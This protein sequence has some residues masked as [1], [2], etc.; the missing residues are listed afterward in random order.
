MTRVAPAENPWEE[1]ATTF[2]ALFEAYGDLH[3][4]MSYASFARKLRAGVAFCED[5]NLDRALAACATAGEDPPVVGGEGGLIRTEPVQRLLD[6]LC[7]LTIE[8]SLTGLFNRRYFRLRLEQEMHRARR[9]YQPLSVLRID[10]D[11]FKK[12]NDTFGH[13]A[14]DRTLCSIARS[15]SE[16]LRSSDEIP[17]RVGGEEFAVLLPDT[18]VAGARIAAERVRSTVEERSR[19]AGPH[20][21][22]SVGATTLDPE[23]N[24]ISPEELVARA[25]RALYDAKKAGRNR[26]CVVAGPPRP[27]T[28]VSHLEKDVLF[29]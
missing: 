27:N 9:S 29:G 14:G 3:G 26:V 28:G 11:E 5:L 25:D 6:H 17:S 24:P 20:V 8:D 7:S 12:L 13:P 16:T 23:E 4:P 22:V 21:T 10:A 1:V 2:A 19:E 18:G 15:I